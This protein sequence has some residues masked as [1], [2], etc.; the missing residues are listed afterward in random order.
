MY[1]FFLVFCC[2]PPCCL[3]LYTCLSPAW[4]IVG[5]RRLHTGEAYE[6]RIQA[7][8]RSRG[9]TDK[10]RR[11]SFLRMRVVEA[12]QALSAPSAE[13]L[14]FLKS[15]RNRWSPSRI[16]CIKSFPTWEKSC[17]L[18]FDAWSSELLCTQNQG[19]WYCDVCGYACLVSTFFNYLSA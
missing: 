13:V 8:D 2:L 19:S 17:P 15:Q 16:R 11:I 6:K 14:L 3:H 18:C 9:E 4:F 10:S 7:P 12:H 1:I 5:R